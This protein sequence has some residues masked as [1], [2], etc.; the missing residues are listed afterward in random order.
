[1]DLETSPRRRSILPVFLLFVTALLIGIGVTAWAVYRYDVIADFL[2]PKPPVVIAP[3][4]LRAPVA[5]PRLAGPLRDKPLV[6][7]VDERL[8]ALER[9]VE[10]VD[11]R[12]SAATGEAA[13]AEGLLVAF[14]ARRALDR[15]TTLGYLEGIL[16]DRFG[17]VEPQAVATVISASR[18]PVTIDQLRDQLDVLSP[19]LTRTS[20]DEGW[21]EGLR[22]EL[23]GLIVIRKAEEPATA[24]VDRI[25]RAR[26]NLAAGHVDSA[27]AEISRLPAQSAAQGWIAAA[28]RYVQ[29]R[30]ALDR[31]ETAALLRPAATGTVVRE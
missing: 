30:V 16:R 2:H 27:L 4:P 3:A 21:W 13:R 28:R 6:P 15:G 29:A 31:I 17:G 12:A 20:P 24:P 23:A 19:K 9:R 26:D 10:E 11:S 25:E 22:R 7:D 5:A 8:D 18:Q 14:A 1:M